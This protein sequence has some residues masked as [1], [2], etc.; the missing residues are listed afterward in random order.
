MRIQLCLLP[1]LG[2]ALT[3]CG[4]INQTMW[5]LQ[6]NHDAIEMSTY[7]IQ[8]NAQAVQEANRAIEENRKYLDE[9]NQALKKATQ[10]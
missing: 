7:A 4:M 1:L 9:I 3:G 2:A 5:A 6:N 8:E 10:T